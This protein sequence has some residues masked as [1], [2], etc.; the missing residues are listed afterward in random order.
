MRTL[1][2]NTRYAS[3]NDTACSTRPKGIEL[4]SE[5]LGFKSF[6]SVAIAAVCVEERDSTLDQD[7]MV[8]EIVKYS[9]QIGKGVV[10]V[11]FAHFARD[12]K[13]PKEAKIVI[14]DIKR[15]LKKLGILVGEVGFGT[16][17]ELELEVILKS[18]SHPGDFAWRES[19]C[20]QEHREQIE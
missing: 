6:E 10:I 4:E 5:F 8:S 7:F 12:L 17:K 18:Y 20:S 9:N 19:R 14:N 16:H 15:K 11:P 3:F 2:I 13:K 1:L